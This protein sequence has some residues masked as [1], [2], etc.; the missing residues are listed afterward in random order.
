MTFGDNHKSTSMKIILAEVRGEEL[1][2]ERAYEKAVVVVGRDPAQCDIVFEQGLWPMVSRRHAE[3]QLKSG[4]CLLIDSNSSFGTFLN[5]QRVTAP[6]EVGQGAR[7]QFGAAGP[8]IAVV[9]FEG[10]ADYSEGPSKARPPDF[11]TQVMSEISSEYAAQ[12]SRKEPQSSRLGASEPSQQTPRSKP[13]QS[14]TP[15][16]L[17]TTQIPA[18]LEYVSGLSTKPEQIRLDKPKTLLGRDPS[19]AIPIDISAAVVSRRHAEIQRRPDGRLVL[20]DLNS[21]NGTLLNNQR[22]AT[23]TLLHDN[24]RIQLGMG[25]PVLRFLDPQYPREDE[26]ASAGSGA[27]T[28][29]GSLGDKPDFQRTIV[30]REPSNQFKRDAVAAEGLNAQLLIERPFDRQKPL[31]TVGR[32]PDNDIS[33]DGL[34]ISNYHARFLR[35]G[36]GRGVMVED[37]GS[38]NGVYVNGARITGRRPVGPE[39]VVQIGP[40]ILRADP[41]RGVAVFDS[42]SKTRIDAIEITK[43]VPSR[44]GRGEVKLLDAISLTIQP[45]EFV[46][47]LGPSG[48]GKSTLMD[49]LNG[50]RPATSGQVLINGLDLYQHPDSLKQSI[51]YV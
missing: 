10:T 4:R 41:D 44:T 18:V 48:A 26:S 3:I 39:D 50:M 14:Q 34:Q 33:V 12:R 28:P 5:G 30:V 40:F 7:I 37:V 47:L 27:A 25:G 9:R 42:R 21:F 13:L 46:G 31:L 38:T 19:S 8:V 22:I 35:N 51:G 45:N 6:V 32:A 15:A 36:D 1:I 29:S 43:I 17:P 11:S 2:G 23:P 24:D 16:A 49:A 20:V